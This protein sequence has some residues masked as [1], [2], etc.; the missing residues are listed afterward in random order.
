MSIEHV[1]IYNNISTQY[2]SHNYKLNIVLHSKTISG[3]TASLY[4]F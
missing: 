1:R 4:V 3:C 2:I